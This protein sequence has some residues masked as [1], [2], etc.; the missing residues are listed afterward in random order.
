ML[1]EEVAG[2]YGKLEGISSRLEMI[3]V[4]T[5]MLK[6]ARKNEIRNIIYLTQGILAPPF[7][8]IEIGVAEKIV[9]DSIALATGNSKDKIE[10]LFRKTGDLGLTAEQMVGSK[11]QGRMSGK[12][13][14]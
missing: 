9:E 12:K 13:F 8:G 10:A 5:E 6:K 4:L 2:Y 7:S 14:D 1:F 11:R 3:D